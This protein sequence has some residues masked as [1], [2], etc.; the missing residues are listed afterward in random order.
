VIFPHYV[1]SNKESYFPEPT[2]F[3][4]ERWLKNEEES[5]KDI[6]RYASLPFGYGRRTCIGRRFAEA[7][8]AILLSKVFFSFSFIRK[9]FHS[10]PFLQIFRK[11]HV[12]YNYGTMNYRVSPTYI[13]DK[14]LK[15]QL[16]ERDS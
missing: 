3:I 12:K 1:L 10:F 9:D 4:P 16:I 7:E 8:L 13:P 2:K 6:H 5:Q 14:P 11:Y 15:F